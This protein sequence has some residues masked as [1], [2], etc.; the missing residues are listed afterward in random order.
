VAKSSRLIENLIRRCDNIAF[1]LISFMML[2]VAASVLSRLLFDLTDGELNLVFPGSIELVS[3]AMLLMVFT[4][5]PRALLNGPIKVELFVAKLPARFNR[6]LNRL[7]NLLLTGF[8]CI[9]SVLFANSTFTM[10]H[11]GD[12]TQDLSVPLYLIYGAATLC[13]IGIVIICIWL[14]FCPQTDHQEN[15]E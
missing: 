5:M 2:T 7:W 6:Q 14:V 15:T 9:I 3:Y 11:R 10:F 12:V 1:F 4:S 13:G 8:F